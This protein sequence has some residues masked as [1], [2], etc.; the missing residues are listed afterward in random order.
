[1][2]QTS[3]SRLKMYN[4]SKS[5]ARKFSNQENNKDKSDCENKSKLK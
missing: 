3:S 2:I 1:M 5:E 4:E